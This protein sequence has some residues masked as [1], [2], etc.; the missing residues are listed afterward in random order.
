MSKTKVPSKVNSERLL[1]VAWR[2][3]TSARVKRTLRTPVDS[4]RQPDIVT[5]QAVAHVVRRPAA[6]VNPKATVATTALV[7]CV[8]I[9]EIFA[10]ITAYR[11]IVDNAIVANSLLAQTLR[12]QANAIFNTAFA[13]LQARYGY[14]SI[15]VDA[16]VRNAD[17]R[18]L[19]DITEI[20]VH[21]VLKLQGL[22][23]RVE[24]ST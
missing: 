20:A 12:A 22:L 6:G 3:Q 2:R 8:R 19:D 16:P 10:H 18:K 9:D 23:G 13:N 14:A 5:N 21:E 24:K 1:N 15:F 17:A 4:S 11:A 7:A